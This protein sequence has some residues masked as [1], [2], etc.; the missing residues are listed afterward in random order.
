VRDGYFGNTPDKQLAAAMDDLFDD[1][2]E[3][4]GA[5]AAPSKEVSHIGRMAEGY[6]L[7]GLGESGTRKSSTFARMIHIRPEFAG[8]SYVPHENR[9]ALISVKA[10]SPCTLRV[11]GITIA[12]AMGL[13]TNDSMKENAVWD[14][15]MDSLPKRGIR[16]IHVDEFQHVLENRNKLDIAK[17]RNTLKRVLQTPGHPVWMLVTGMPEC[18]AVLEGDTQTWRRTSHVFFQELNF[19]AHAGKCRTMVE[20]FATEKAELECKA[21]TTDD[22]IHRLMHASLFR[23]GIAIDVVIKSIRV[24]LKEEAT[25]LA[26]E[27]FAKAYKAFAGC[28]DAEN[29]FAVK[30]G[31]AGI[32]VG[33]F[34]TRQIEHR[35]ASIAGAQA[36]AAK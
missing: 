18:G 26:I 34:L 6:P 25:S 5:K 20:F 12:R 27:H 30:E 9:S 7:F 29:P 36:K 10:P 19:S 15:I 22:N 8:F 4:L 31:Y 11:L 33:K 2:F 28:A 23:L 1:I 16:V 35:N 14:D 17:I 24:A 32:E 21:F 3:T 13:P